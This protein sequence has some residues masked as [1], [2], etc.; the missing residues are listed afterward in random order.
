[1]IIL[2]GTVEIVKVL[3]VGGS[4]FPL[5]DVVLV[6]TCLKRKNAHPTLRTT[7][8]PYAS[9]NMAYELGA[10]G[11]QSIGSAA[12]LLIGAITV[13]NLLFQVI[14]VVLSVL[15]LPGTSVSFS[16]ILRHRLHRL[17]KILDSLFRTKRLMGCRHRCQR[18]NRQAIC[19]AIGT[20]RLQ[21]RSRLSNRVET[22]RLDD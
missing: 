18:W 21:Y 9:S 16:A 13:A 2:L 14:R 1:M 8:C 20:C 17:I 3:H 12:L 22:F 7:L 5:T 19:I 6:C 15:V 10:L 4:D 11:Q